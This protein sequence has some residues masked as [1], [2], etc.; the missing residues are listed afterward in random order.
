[1]FFQFLLHITEAMFVG[2]YWL[3]IVILVCVLVCLFILVG[4]GFELRALHLQSIW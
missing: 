1:M 4:L 3:G 2:A